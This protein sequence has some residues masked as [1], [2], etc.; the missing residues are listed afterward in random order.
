MQLHEDGDW[1]LNLDCQHLLAFDQHLYTQIV[2]YPAEVTHLLDQEAQLLMSQ[3]CGEDAEAMCNLLVR[4]NSYIYVDR[5]KVQYQ[6]D[7][8]C[9]SVLQAAGM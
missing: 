4:P 6:H 2:A 5:H 3:L 1:V 8:T 7:F 9:K